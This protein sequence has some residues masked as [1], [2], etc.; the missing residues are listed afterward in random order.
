VIGNETEGT[1]PDAQRCA[2]GRVSIPMPGR[3]ESLNA[4]V[5]ASIIIFESVRQR[6]GRT[7]GIHQPDKGV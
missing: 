4:S 7:H 6:L 1:R 2:T 3:A 5:A